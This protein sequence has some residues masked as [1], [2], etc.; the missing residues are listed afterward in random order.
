MPEHNE[1]SALKYDFQEPGVFRV[2]AHVAL[3]SDRENG[4]TPLPTKGISS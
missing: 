4:A 1:N 2:G 3:A